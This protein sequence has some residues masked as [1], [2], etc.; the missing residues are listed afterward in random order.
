MKTKRIFGV[1]V[2]AFVMVAVMMCITL[3]G[4]GSEGTSDGKTHVNIGSWP[5]KEGK[6]LDKMNSKKAEF[7]AANPDV[8]IEP[9]TYTLDMQSFYPKAEAKLLPDVMSV[10]FTEVK[11]LVDGGYVKDLTKALK[12]NGVYDEFSPLALKSVTFDNKVA[13]FPSNIYMLGLAVNM[14][15]FEKAGFVDAD[16][17]PKQ[18]KD[19]YELAEMAV[20]IK[21]KTGKPGFMLPTMNNCGGWMFSSIAWSFGVDF[22]EQDKDGNWKATFNTPE[23]KAALEF[24]KDLKW[25]YDVVPGNNLIDLNEYY[26]QYA[27]GNAAMIIAPNSV[28]NN[29][30]QY[31]T[32]LAMVGMVA[33]PKGPKRHVSLMGG[34]L[35]FVPEYATDEQVDAAVRWIKW[36]NNSK[37]TDTVKEN[38]VNSFEISKEKGALIGIETISIWNDKSEIEKFRA[39]KQ[40][41]YI[42]INPNHVRLYNES[43]KDTSIE[44]QAEEPVCCQDLYGILDNC[45]QQ[46]FMDKNADCAAI[47]EKANTDFQTNFLNNI[48]Y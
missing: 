28:G 46:V 19:W 3:A 17:T 43:L 8:V 31:E 47:L 9:D 20:K 37:L 18:P 27:I 38:I 35:T 44:L 48:S 45:I 5:A 6:E 32:D 41:E 7:E 12:E 1:K 16:G 21:E 11:Q 24:I 23:A 4:C 2:I 25:K 34:A 42:N 15:L 14:D 33:M 10:H 29:V 39:E 26:K 22:M 40:A 36:S 13:G 30:A